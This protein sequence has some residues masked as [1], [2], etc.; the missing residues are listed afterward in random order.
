LKASDE[1]EDAAI[2]VNEDVKMSSTSSRPK[3]KQEKDSPIAQNAC[4]IKIPDD[5]IMNEEDPVTI[6]DR[7]SFQMMELCNCLF[8]GCIRMY[9]HIFPILS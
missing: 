3:M 9:S 1:I 7:L 2:E 4:G 5:S 6:V 8:R